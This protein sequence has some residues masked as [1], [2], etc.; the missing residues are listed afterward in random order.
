MLMIYYTYR[1]TTSLQKMKI[2]SSLISDMFAENKILI[3][4]YN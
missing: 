4:V 2:S 1:R 3:K